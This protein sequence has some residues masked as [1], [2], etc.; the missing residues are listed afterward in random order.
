MDWGLVPTDDGWIRHDQGSNYRYVPKKN[1]YSK[2]QKGTYSSTENYWANNQLVAN[3]V[4]LIRFSDVLLWAAEC[5]IQATG[6]D[7]NKALGYV[8][9]IRIRAANPAGWVYQYKDNTDPSKGFS[10]TPA[11]NY[12]VKPYPAGAFASKPYALKAIMFERRLELA[13]EGH[14]FFDLVRW[15]VADI[16]LNQY[17]ND[18]KGFNNTYTFANGATFTKGKSEYFAIPQGQIDALNSKGTVVL[19]Q[20]PGY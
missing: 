17:A 3:N 11:D 6:G 19:K 2:G 4:N 7:A 1:I 20:N 10:T 5:E 16:T 8:N 12:S 15:G 14:R 9:Q 13:M 18:E